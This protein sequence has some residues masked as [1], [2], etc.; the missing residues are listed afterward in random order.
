MKTK[1]CF[2]L[3]IGFVLLISTPV[4]L[5]SA[6]QDSS[7]TI[8]VGGTGSGNVSS[9]SEAVERADN[10]DHIFVYPGFYNET[11]VVDKSVQIT[12]MSKESTVVNGDMWSNVFHITAADV[13]IANLTIQNTGVPVINTSHADG[14]NDTENQDDEGGLTPTSPTVDIKTIAIN[15]S[16]VFSEAKGTMVSGCLFQT[17]SSGI[18]FRNMSRGIISDCMFTDNAKAG[19]FIDVF[20]TEIFDC[21]LVENDI[22]FYFIQSYD[23]EVYGNTVDSNVDTGFLFSS[24]DSSLVYQNQFINNT[25]GVVLV[26]D[27]FDNIFY[28]NNFMENRVFHVRDNCN[29]S[30]DNGVKG[31]YWDDYTGTDADGDGIGDTAYFIPVVSEDSFPLIDIVETGSGSLSIT[32][33]N[34]ADETV[35]ESDVDQ[36]MV[37]GTV[38]AE[39]DVSQVFVR[40]DTNEW[41]LAEGTSE[42]MKTIDLTNLEG[43][44]HTIFVSAETTTGFSSVAQSSF[45]IETENID[46]ETGT[47][48]TD[49]STPTD[50]ETPGFSVVII[51]FSVLFIGIAF[52]KYQLKK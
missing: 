49:N 19:Y 33:T 18:V 42:W 39:E 46:D 37:E 51:L 4:N 22:G 52:K 25:I 8:Y 12:G 21:M 7:E 2:V 30:W 6:D 17:C 34:P 32:I 41:L 38:V 23:L 9:I 15:F 5:V 16:G 45:S 14:S 1:T 24:A 44:M 31:N 36:I 10:G 20:E 35:F 29:N 43:G 28:K 48:E 40:I 3:M 26:N 50:E 11:V 27:C 13:T 47:N